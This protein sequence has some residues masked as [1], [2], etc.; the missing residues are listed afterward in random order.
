MNKNIMEILKAGTKQSELMGDDFIG[1]KFV[2]SNAD[3]WNAAILSR[4]E[5]NPEEV[6]DMMNATA[7]SENG[8]EFV[9]YDGEVWKAYSV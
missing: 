4:Y 3:F 9:D 2:G 8:F 5:E 6:I 7:L 1:F